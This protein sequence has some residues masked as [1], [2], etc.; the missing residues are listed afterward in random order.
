MIVACPACQGK[1]C[2]ECHDAGTFEVRQCPQELITP[3]VWQA[4]YLADLFEKGLPPVAG[5]TLDQAQQFIDAALFAWK[6]ADAWKAK[7]WKL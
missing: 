7:Q 3:D 5:G 2:H 1:G 6:E 4:L